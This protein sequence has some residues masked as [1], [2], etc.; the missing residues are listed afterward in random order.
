MDARNLL[1]LSGVLLVLGATGYYWGMGHQKNTVTSSTEA[2]RPDYVIK[3]IHSQETDTDGR[4]LR[5]LMAPEVRHYDQ[6]ADEAEMDKPVLT[7]YEHGQE[8]WRI[9]ALKGSSTSRNTEL[10]L[11]GSVHAERRDPAAIPIIF[12]TDAVTVFPQEKRISSHA[13][14]TINSPQGHLSSLGIDANMK[15]GDLLLNEKVTGNYAPASR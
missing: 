9:T 13:L 1:S 4:I 11:K 14:V 10:Y 3:D 15:T 12:D 7:L 5:R 8:A 2:R 6:P